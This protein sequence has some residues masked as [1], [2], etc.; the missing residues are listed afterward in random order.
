MY[1]MWA[2]FAACV[3]SS[4]VAAGQ[5]LEGLIEPYDVVD[6]S[7]QIP[8]VLDDVPV[9]RGDRVTKGQV[10]ARLKSDLDRV[11]VDLARAQL[12]FAKR[13]AERNAELFK[14]ELLSVHEQD[15]METEIEVAALQLRQAE[16]RLKLRTIRSPINGVVIDKKLSPGEYVGE[17]AI[18]TVAQI[19]P[20]NVEVIAPVLLFGSVRVGDNAFVL[21][22]EPV[23]GR[24][25]AKV[26]IVDRV[27]DAASGTFGIR[28]E[29]PNA[30]YA[31]PAGLKCTVEISVSR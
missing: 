14:K 13:R 4:N 16:E 28:L 31:L 23:G 22:E 18:L 30:D 6:I 1:L 5:S 15:E 29:L 27:V 12:G 11:A 19:D 25:P 2:L 17:S 21:A 7:S 20:L 9:R 26:V 8:G 3:A 10:L 24:H